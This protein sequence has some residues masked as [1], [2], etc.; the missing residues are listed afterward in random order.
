MA[1]K[2]LT[3]EHPTRSPSSIHP[4]IHPYPSLL[5]SG[6]PRKLYKRP[7]RPSKNQRNQCFCTRHPPKKKKV[8]SLRVPQ[9]ENRN[10]GKT[11]LMDIPKPTWPFRRCHHLSRCIYDSKWGF[12][13]CYVILPEFIVFFQ[14]NQKPLRCLGK[15]QLTFDSPQPYKLEDFPN[16]RLGCIKPCTLPETNIATEN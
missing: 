10:Y 6:L 3:T 12:P 8:P 5:R 2:R 1:F 14:S 13:A 7:K 15:L 11:R 16:N 4:S 9:G